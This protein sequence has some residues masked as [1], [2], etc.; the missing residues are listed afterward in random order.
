MTKENILQKVEEIKKALEELYANY[1]K[2]ELEHYTLY[3][4][5]ITENPSSQMNRIGAPAPAIPPEQWPRVSEGEGFEDEYYE[6][7]EY[8]E[9]ENEEYEEEE[10]Y[11]EEAPMMQHLLS[12]DLNTIPEIKK[13]LKKKL[14]TLS[15]FIS[16]PWENEAYFPNNGETA[17]LL[18]EV[19]EGEFI[20][21][22]VKEMLE[23]E[24]SLK[25][26]DL[27]ELQVPT[28]VFINREELNYLA[29]QNAAPEELPAQKRIFYDWNNFLNE[30]DPN[31][32]NNFI[33]EKIR[34]K[35]FNLPAYI[36]GEPIWIQAPEYDGFFI[37]QFS[38]QFIDMNLGDSGEMYVF[39]D[40]AFWQCY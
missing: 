27:L 29:P 7:E 33:I 39:T 1:P 37:M 15:L 35:I 25:Y 21:E 38:E 36:G 3:I 19:T 13:H 2:E 18:H 16:D 26:F 32:W 4:P 6:D 8:E 12:L 40:T 31:D 11:N 24:G 20:P 28:A 30:N 5:Y 14:Q 23:E 10:D 22:E 34:H 17:V 9:S